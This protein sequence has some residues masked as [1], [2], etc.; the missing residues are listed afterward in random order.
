MN[1]AKILVTVFLLAYASALATAASSGNPGPQSA[2]GTSEANQTPPNQPSSTRASAQTS[3]T[4]TQP[5]PKPHQR[6]P[7]KSADI[8]CASTSQGVGT[9]SAATK[10]PAN[11]PPQKTVVRNGGTSEPELQ[12][13]QG[14]GA[15]QAQ[16]RSIT[17]QL[18]GSTEENLKK[19]SGHE[20]TASQQDM[21]S[22][23]R[24]YMAQ[25][26]EAV[27]AGDT[28]RSRMLAQKAQLLSDELVKP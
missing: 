26:K 20:L 16:Q 5:K 22:Q 13:T 8:N 9:A 17:D 3:S 1:L 7:K 4:Q 14:G 6:K 28:E 15:T 2:P 11:C 10:P 23:I 19:I 24:Q 25:S 18:L 27:S 12:L 21:V